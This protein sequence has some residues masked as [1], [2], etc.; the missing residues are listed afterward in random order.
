MTRTIS[1]LQSWARDQFREAGLPTPALDADILLT[2]ALEI[3]RETLIAYPERAVS[4]TQQKAFEAMVARRLAREPVSRILGVREFWGLPFMIN[5]YTLD[6][7]PDSETLIEVALAVLQDKP[8]PRILDL[9]TGSGC[10]LLAV[11]TLRMNVPCSR[12]VVNV[13]SRA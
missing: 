10:L 8:N 7:R 2:A 11:W 12:S 6:P 9:G 5:E 13:A 4:S 3:R 1:A